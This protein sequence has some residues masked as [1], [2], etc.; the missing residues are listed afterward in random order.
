MTTAL[1]ILGYVAIGVIVAL[2]FSWRNI[3][4]D[5]VSMLVVTYF[6]PA[7]TIWWIFETVFIKGLGDL[8]KKFNRKV[9]KWRK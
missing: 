7:F 5:V 6:W 1:Y 9:K 2:F 4:R 3:T 8:Y